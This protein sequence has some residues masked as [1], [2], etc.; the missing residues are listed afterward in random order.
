MSWFSDI[1]KKVGRWVRRA[2]AIFL[3][4]A[5]ILLYVAAIVLTG[6]SFI[7]GPWLLAFAAACMALAFV[8]LNLASTIDQVDQLMSLPSNLRYWVVAVSMTPWSGSYAD[9][10]VEE[11][12]TAISTA[13]NMDALSQQI[14]DAAE[15]ELS[16]SRWPYY[17][18][19]ED[20]EPVE[21]QRGPTD[22]IAVVPADPTGDTGRSSKSSVGPA[23]VAAGAAAALLLLPGAGD[24]DD[25]SSRV[26]RG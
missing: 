24:S 22:E 26:T 7:F 5:T 16:F 19:L 9:I 1:F 8:T 13:V 23:V 14:Y 3:Y 21:P 2:L 6:L 15:S 11:A 4:I 20:G 10:D 12:I 18:L 25:Q 17:V